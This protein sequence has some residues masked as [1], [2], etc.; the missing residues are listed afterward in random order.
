MTFN[1]GLNVTQMDRQTEKQNRQTSGWGN[2]WTGGQTGRYKISSVLV[3]FQE[4]MTKG[5]FFVLNSEFLRMQF[6]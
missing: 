4:W 3:V 5:N 6:E 1:S 2:K